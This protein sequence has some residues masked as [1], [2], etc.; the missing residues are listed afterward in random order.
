[1]MKKL[2]SQLVLLLVALGVA[3]NAK[4]QQLRDVVKQ[5][6]TSVVVVKTVEKNL[7]T[8]PQS[9]FVSS[10][11]CGSGVLISSDGKVL[12]AA[13]VVQA[14][15]KV[16][17][18]FSDGQTAPAKVIASVPGADVA[19]L[20]LDWVPYNAKPA[21][22]GD[23][24]R[25]QVGDD[26]FII[27]APY[28]IGHSLSAGH[29]SARRAPKNPAAA[30]LSLE[31][32]QTDAAI[33]KGN[34]GGPMFNLAGEVVGIVSSILSQSGGSEGLGF[35]IT[36]NTAQRLLVAKKGFWSGVDGL[37]LSGEWVRI[38]NI[39]Q[40]A[41][42]L[43]Q[44]IADNSPAA[45]IGLLGGTYKASVAGEEML[46]GGDIILA[47]GGITV[48]PDGAALPKI[49]E[50]LSNLKTGEVVTIKVLRAGQVTELKT[51]MPAH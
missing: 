35:A 11:G 8:A 27:G 14:A 50:Y 46:V 19:M 38:F 23:S 43:V 2:I 5:V 26:V 18:E 7:L 33:N 30:T 10:P 22:L 51:N 16:E 37:L 34:S 21:K 49:L 42:L 4:A 13:H 48:V 15:D 31:L 25:M 24:D 3:A 41:G 29:V 20:K 45:S 17:V 6:D 44:R 12:T 9:M 39:P 28:G 32:L 47:V 1:M 40:S 36:S